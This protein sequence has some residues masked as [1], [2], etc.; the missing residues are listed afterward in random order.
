MTF[1]TELTKTPT[2][3][4]DISY[5]LFD[6]DPT[7]NEQRMADFSIQVKD[8]DSE[9][10]RVRTGEMIQHMLPGE[11]QTMIDLLDAWRTRA[12]AAMIP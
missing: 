9:I 11:I 4:A 2:A 3:L 12:T 8:Q 5:Q 10:M 7:G 6:P 1:Q